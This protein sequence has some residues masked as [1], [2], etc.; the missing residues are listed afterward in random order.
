MVELVVL[1]PGAPLDLRLRAKNGSAGR[2]EL[3]E[4]KRKGPGMRGVRLQWIMNRPR[5]AVLLTVVAV[6]LLAGCPKPKLIPNTKVLD[7]PENREIVDTAE[8]YRLAVERRDAAA[9]LAMAAP[10]YYQPATEANQGGYDRQGLAAMLRERFRDVESVRYIIEYLDVRRER[11]R[12]QVDIYIDATFQIK[13]G[14]TPRWRRMTDYARL[15][16]AWNGNRW[17]F[18]SGM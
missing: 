18:T 10:E 15:Q 4:A 2:A 12:A 5:C 11:E 8:A 16:L 13:T 14:A 7:T 6:G 3:A 17:L 9:L 1:A